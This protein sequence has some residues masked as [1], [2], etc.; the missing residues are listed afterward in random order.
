MCAYLWKLIRQQVV[1]DKKG[2]PRV[3]SSVWRFFLRETGKIGEIKSLQLF[4][5]F[6][7]HFFY[8]I[9]CGMGNGGVG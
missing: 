5:R 9:D 3:D 1:E 2:T 6:I 4:V 8:S 7:Q